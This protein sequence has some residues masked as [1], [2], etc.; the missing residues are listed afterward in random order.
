MKSIYL[1]II[2]NDPTVAESL[3]AYL[4]EKPEIA[5][6]IRTV[7]VESFLDSLSGNDINKP[8][9]ILLDIQLPGISGIQGIP[10]I[11]KNLPRS[12]IIMLT[13]FEDYDKVFLAL[14]A[15]A[16]SYISK[17]STLSE[18]YECIL[19]VDKGGS[20]MSPCIGKM[21]T[22]YFANNSRQY[23]PLSNRQSEIINTIV[24]G[25]SYKMVGVKL[26][27]PIDTVRTHIMQIYRALN[28]HTKGELI[29]WAMNK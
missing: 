14:C 16:S 1:A 19:T 21:V 28:I 24:E 5:I 12:E 2:E 18:I 8:E 9:I 10:F 25:L 4:G 6:A 17:Q 22:Q 27:I 20:Y 29:R 3:E 15:G 13:T 7:N 23:N 26:N 11:K